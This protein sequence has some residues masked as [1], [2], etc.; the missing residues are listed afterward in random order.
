VPIL[1]PNPSLTAYL[2]ISLSVLHTLA[3]SHN[4]NIAK[5]AANLIVARCIKAP[6]LV[7]AVQADAVSADPELKRKARVAMAFLGKWA[8]GSEMENALPTGMRTGALNLPPSMVSLDS[9]FDIGDEM[10]LAAR[11]AN[12]RADEGGDAAVWTTI[13]RDGPSSTEANPRRRNREAMVLQG[14]SEEQ[15]EEEFIH[16]RIRPT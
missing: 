13:V 9:A 14:G 2:V 4:P 8:V 12:F 15:E 3:T 6:S 16:T 1:H 10:V 5:S 11:S 7:S